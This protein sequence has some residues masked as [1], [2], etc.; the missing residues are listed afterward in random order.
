MEL[1]LDRIARAAPARALRTTA[2]YHE[3]VDDP[4]KNETVIKGVFLFGQFDEIARGNRRF[5]FEK[6]N[7]KVAL[8]CFKLGMSIC[9]GVGILS[10]SQPGKSS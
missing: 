6:F 8:G 3:P 5:V 1:I 2:L 9:H 7:F 4:V 10:I